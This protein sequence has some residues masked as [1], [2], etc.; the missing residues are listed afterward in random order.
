MTRSSFAI[1]TPALLAL[2]PCFMIAPSAAGQQIPEREWHAAVQSLAEV[3]RDHYV[4]PDV[5]SWLADSIARWQPGPGDVVSRATFMDSLLADV[6][7][8]SGDPHFALFHPSLPPPPLDPRVLGV[9]SGR[10]CWA[11]IERRGDVRVL[12]DIVRLPAPD[13]LACAMERVLD[14][15]AI[16]LDLRTCSGGSRT[17]VA[18]LLGYFVEEPTHFATYIERGV[19]PEEARTDDVRRGALGRARIAVLIGPET[20]SGCEAVAYHL[21]QLGRATVIGAR[22]RGASH[23]VRT[24]DLAEGYRAFVPVIRSSSPTTGSDWE[25]TGVMP[26]IAV[27]ATDGLAE[28][29]RRIGPTG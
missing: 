11:E 24:Y 21:Q 6:T 12:D 7:R 15:D 1:S 10:A 29:V 20:A 18:A 3:V 28:A 9:M 27:A 26:D 4:L 5:A 13:R 8:W 14:A 22:S 17:S 16:V 23:A 2:L 19:P 25:G